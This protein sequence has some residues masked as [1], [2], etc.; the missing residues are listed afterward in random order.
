MTKVF[1]YIKGN[2]YYKRGYFAGEKGSD[3]KEPWYVTEDGTH[4][5]SFDVD[6]KPDNAE[7]FFKALKEAG[8]NENFIVV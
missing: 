4:W 6:F 2:N 7:E 8:C 5:S 1:G 3:S